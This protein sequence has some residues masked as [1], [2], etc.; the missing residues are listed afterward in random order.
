MH[1][2]THLRVLE[3]VEPLLAKVLAAFCGEETAPLWCQ[4]MQTVHSALCAAASKQ[5]RSLPE[6]LSTAVNVE[7]SVQGAPSDGMRRPSRRSAAGQLVLRARAI[8]LLEACVVSMRDA[9][10][11][12]SGGAASDEAHP[13]ALWA[14]PGLLPI[15]SAASGAATSARMCAPCLHRSACWVP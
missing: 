4:C 9:I 11:K 7:G 12:A 15:P 1:A 5:G 14:M 6:A 13:M 2:E 8:A 3:A 10:C